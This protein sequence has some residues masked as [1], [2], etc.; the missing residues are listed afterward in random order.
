M[1]TRSGVVVWKRMIAS[2][3]GMAPVAVEIVYWPAFPDDPD[4]ENWSIQLTG[5]LSGL[6]AREATGVAAALSAAAAEVDA[7]GRPAETDAERRWMRRMRG[8][9]QPAVG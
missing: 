8:Q 6:T 7:A 2:A 4:S 1:T 9:E 3:T 5:D